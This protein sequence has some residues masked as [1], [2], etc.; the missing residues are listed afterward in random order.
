MPDYMPADMIFIPSDVLYNNSWDNAN[1]RVRRQDLAQLDDTTVLYLVHPSENKFVFPHPGKFLSPFGYRGRH[2]H[3]GVDLKLNLGDTV[4][5][6]FDGKVRL[7]RK[8]RGYGN[9]VVV[10][11]YNGL[12]TVYAHLSKIIV[13]VNDDVKAGEVVGLGGRT[14][15]AT[16]NHLH[17]ETRF[18][19]EPFNPNT[20]I[21]FDNFTLSKDT[22]QITSALFS[23]GA[24]IRNPKN[25]KRGYQRGNSSSEPADVYVVKKGDTLGKIAKKNNTTIVALCKANKITKKTALKIGRRLKIS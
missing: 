9:L 20:F 8:Y 4:V 17:F 3:A 11:H 14:G 7:A 2:F 10:R 6:A 12:E 5:S 1:V 16:A 23:Y 22:V 21:D 13:H 15:R 18:L 19:G 24:K 25:G